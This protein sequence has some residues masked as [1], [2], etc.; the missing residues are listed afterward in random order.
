MKKRIIIFG[1]PHCG[2]SILK[3]VMGH[4]AGVEE[5]YDESH[6]IKKFPLWKH[7]VCKY[8]FL[9]PKFLSKRYAGYVKIFVIRNPVW[10]FSSLNKRFSYNIPENHGMERYIETIKKFIHYR[11]EKQKN[12]YLIRYEDM[13]DEEFKNLRVIFDGIGLKYKNEIFDNTKFVN[14][15]ISNIEE[16]PKERPKNVDHA[17]YRTY[18]INQPFVNNNTLSKIDLTE[19][20]KHVLLSDGYIKQVYPDIGQYL[21]L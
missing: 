19:E 16:V 5:I 8:P 6:I 15:I 17:K 18:Q 21:N 10:V 4:I 12:L 9:L 2:T 14:K 7:I 1:F 13:F 20:Q 11:Q 3:S